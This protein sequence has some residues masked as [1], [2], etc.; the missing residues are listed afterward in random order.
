AETQEYKIYL[1]LYTLV[2][3][4]MRVSELCDLKWSDFSEGNTSK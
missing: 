4:G 2:T 3:T 1:M